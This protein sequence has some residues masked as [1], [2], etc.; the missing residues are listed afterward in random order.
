MFV[1]S[2]HLQDFTIQ[3][4][5][6]EIGTVEQFYFDDE[7]WAI[8]YLVAKTGSWLDQRQVLISPFSIVRLDMVA[9]R[10]EVSLTQKQV[11]NSPGIDTQRPVSR[12]HEIAYMDYYGYPYYWSGPYMWGPA[13]YPAGLAA[14]TK[15]GT[16]DSPS[17][18]PHNL[19]KAPADVH[20]RST[21]AVSRYHIESADGEIGHV[22]GFV[23]DEEAWVIRYIEVATRNWLPGKKVLISPAW[24]EKVKW[25]D[26]KVY[27]GLTREA[28]QSAPEHIESRLINRE[29]EDRLYFHFGRPPYWLNE[30]QYQP[31][32][33][34]SGA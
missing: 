12:Q 20:L 9:K 26:S 24:V 19:W 28:I 11:E 21:Q 22:D 32:Y 14:S 30:G 16:A 3:A 8:R 13:M 18:A 23:I 6:G 10:L 5:D 2:K 17:A 4:S 15:A 25:E 31:A 34:V 27:V 33:S 7:T 1:N 29:F